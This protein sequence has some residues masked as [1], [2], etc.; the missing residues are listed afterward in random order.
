MEL[1]KGDV[2]KTI[3]P[4]VDKDPSL[5]ISLLYLDMDLYQPTLAAL[6]A[7]LPRMPKGSIIVFDEMACVDWPGESKAMLD[8]FDLNRYELRRSP[9]VPHIG[10]LTL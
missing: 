1:V 5:I 10:Y 4:F 9:I 8:R 3:K 2:S 6:D 7:C